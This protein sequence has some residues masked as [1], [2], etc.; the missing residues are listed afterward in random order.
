MMTGN[1]ID[2]QLFWFVVLLSA[3]FIYMVNTEMNTLLSGVMETSTGRSTAAGQ[4][5]K[6]AIQMKVIGENI[7]SIIFLYLY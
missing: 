4:H 1:S 6:T 7:S 2:A 5:R 3:M